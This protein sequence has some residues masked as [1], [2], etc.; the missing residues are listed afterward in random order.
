MVVKRIILISLLSFYALFNFAQDSTFIKVHFLYGSKPAKGYKKTE[1]KYFGGI[2]GGHVVVEIGDSIYGFSPAQPISRVFA[3]K[4][5]SNGNFHLE[6]GYTFYYD[7]LH[8]KLLSIKIPVSKSEFSV[9]RKHA[10]KYLNQ[11]PFDYALFGMRCASTAHDLLAQAGIFKARNKS[12]YI[13]KTFYPRKLRKRLLDLALEKKYEI[14][15]Q[16]GRKERKWEKDKRRH[17]KKLVP[18]IKP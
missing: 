6:K 3:K 12:G 14:T 1:S 2:M 17:R 11:T 8:Q 7:T 4:S 9:I 16:V 18:T 10:I 13:L 15:Y 5:F